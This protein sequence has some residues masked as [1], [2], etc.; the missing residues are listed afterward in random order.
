[1]KEQIICQ[2]SDSREDHSVAICSQKTGGW[3]NSQKTISC[4]WDPI[5]EQRN[6]MRKEWQADH[7]SYSIFPCA[8]G[9]GE[10]EESGVKLSLGGRKVWVVLVLFL[11][12][13]LYFYW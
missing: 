5:L 6:S 1:M 13:Q 12:I 9:S 3:K 10:V 2:I 8:T 7:N 11:T 4:G